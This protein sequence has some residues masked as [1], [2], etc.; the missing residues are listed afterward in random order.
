LQLSETTVAIV[1][2]GLMG[3]S[4]GL[5]L[6]GQGSCKEVRALVRRSEA[7]EA[8][9]ARGAANV[10]GTDPGEMLKLADIVVLAAPVRTIERQVAELH[11]FLKPG[12]V[13]TDMGSVKAGVVAAMDG[14]PPHVRA[15]AGHPMAG[16]ETP[17][18]AA[19][20]ADLFRNRV[21]V[22]TPSR[23]SDPEAVGILKDLI[24]AV[25]ACYS[26]MDADIHDA[27]VACISHLPFLLAAT[28][29]GVA[30]D[31]AT[32]RPEVWDLAAGGFRD[33]TRVA[34]GDLTM[35]MDILAANR[36]NVL[37]ML[38]RASSGIDRFIRLVNEGDEPT[39]R[40]VLSRARQRRLG[41]FKGGQVSA[42]GTKAHV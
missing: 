22:L 38:K 40:E 26:L 34:A 5:A 23:R 13:M 31:T 11:R 1:G 27:A 2:M 42:R 10:A 33:T 7:A 14:L 41:M 32:E 21:W 16:K 6:A 30:E 37:E 24:Y 20:D 8:V 3:G 12:T 17:G 4:L 25:G 19:A 35:M 39:L 29:V 15:V 28:L 18:L 9:V 36:D